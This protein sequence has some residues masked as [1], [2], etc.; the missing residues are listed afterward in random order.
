MN[1]DISLISFKLKN[2]EIISLTAFEKL[3]K[4]SGAEIIIITFENIK[5]QKKNDEKIKENLYEIIPPEFCEYI[6]IFSKKILDIFSP[7]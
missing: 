6:Y 1:L 7:H 5:M 3:A 2:T 4:K